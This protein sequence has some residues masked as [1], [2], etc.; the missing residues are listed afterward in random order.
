MTQAQ[1]FQP[2][3]ELT[4]Y[5]NK[6]VTR[7]NFDRALLAAV[8]SGLITLGSLGKRT[9]YECLQMNYGLVREDIP[10]RFDFFVETLE[11][12]FGKAAC[13]IEMQIME[14][15]HQHCPDFE[16]QSNINAFSFR[17]FVKTFKSCL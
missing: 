10:Q 14:T 16:F 15:M 1:E 17:Q 3:F 13:L 2:V 6:N 9:F 8:D 5:Q 4:T 11:N 12:I 7:E